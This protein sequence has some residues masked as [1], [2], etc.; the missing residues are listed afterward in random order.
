MIDNYKP[1]KGRAIIIGN[2]DYNRNN[3]VPP[4]KTAVN[5]ANKLAELLQDK[6]HE[7]DCVVK[8]NLTKI[9]F[10][11]L[12]ETQAKLISEDQRV[13]FYFAGHGIPSLDDEKNGGY[14]A[15]IDANNNKQESLLPM[16]LF[17]E[18]LMQFNCRHFLL[19]LDCCFA[20]SFKWAGNKRDILIPPKVIYK[21]RFHAY[22]NQ[23]AWQV[24]TSSSA[25]QKAFDVFEPFGTRIIDQDSK[26]S[27]FAEG[28]FYGLEGNSDA[29]DD[30]IIT[31]FELYDCIRSKV[32]FLTLKV[33][34]NQRQTPMLFNIDEKHDNGLC[35]FLTEKFRYQNLQPKRNKNPYKGLETYNEEDRSLFY[36]RDKVIKELIEHVDKNIFTVVT[37]ASGTGKSSVVR[38]GLI[39]ELNEK[40][41]CKVIR[42]GKNPLDLINDALIDIMQAE[43]KCLIIDQFEE[44]V[45]QTE[46]EEDRIEFI[47]TIVKL[48]EKKKLDKIIITIRLDFEPQF[49][50]Y[51][52][53]NWWEKG[54]FVVT[55]LSQDEVREIIEQPAIQEIISFNPKALVDNIVNDVLEAT[56]VLPLLSY[57]LYQLYE[58]SIKE[59]YRTNELHQDDYKELNGVIG[60]LQT[61]ADKVFE[62]LTITEQETMK[63]V[64][65]RMVSFKGGELAKRTVSEDELVYVDE[66][67]NIRVK[68][69]LD[70][71]TG[72]KV[73]LLV[74][75]NSG[76][77]KTYEPL[78]DAL[79]TSWAK[80]LQ[81]R[82]Q[83]N[84][85]YNDI[86]DMIIMQDKV[87]NAVIE[88]QLYAKD[89]ARLWH[90][91][92]F[93]LPI[94]EHE[95]LKEKE[96]WLNKQEIEFVVN[97]IKLRKRNSIILWGSIIVAFLVLAVLT[98]YALNQT[99]VANKQTKL[100]NEKTKEASEQRDS[101]KLQLIRMQIAETDRL[102]QIADSYNN[103]GE[104]NLAIK[105]CEKALDT[106]PNIDI[107]IK[108]HLAIK[109]DSI[110]SKLT[111]KETKDNK[112]YLQKIDSIKQKHKL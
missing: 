10:L 83:Q 50:K 67:E 81:W 40:Y 14:L 86:A 20:G 22:E 25:D 19:I 38:A 5:D 109:L 87:N 35:F 97:S 57:M 2:N 30:G 29:N 90:R 79:I 80:L 41:Q 93:L 15:L 60:A 16:Q 63:K 55:P 4:L 23:A 53:Q 18:K 106:F 104:Y 59:K 24:I 100:A 33:N 26:H 7:F 39:P 98:I 72:E 107:S 102:I 73:R 89:S 99:S 61:T 94:F 12:I 92:K 11:D 85:K 103:Y 65:L 110:T 78:H 46:K 68:K 36:G 70:L 76:D 105:M 52:L 1:L 95:I 42:P 91:D 32:D 49:N 27:P 45:T 54:R 112:N 56:N 77:Q 43:K 37:G 44:I 64:M 9:E 47:T 69:I 66:E 101:A 108:K 48:I 6:P 17:Y 84:K 13:L 51:D 74:A 62:S 71:M 82:N 31:I 3:G 21:E 88:Y 58:K 111:K 96:N 28:L 34:E 75:G 8:N